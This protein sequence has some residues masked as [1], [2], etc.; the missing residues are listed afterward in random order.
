MFFVF[1]DFIDPTMSE[2]DSERVQYTKNV[3]L[4]S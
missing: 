2:Q 3:V 1:E 4:V